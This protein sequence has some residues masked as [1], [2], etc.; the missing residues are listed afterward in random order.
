M[1]DVSSHAELKAALLA[2]EKVRFEDGQFGYKASAARN[3]MLAPHGHS[4]PRAARQP[5]HNIRSAA[6][7]LELLE[8]VRARARRCWRALMRA[9]CT[10]SKGVRAGGEGCEA[11]HSA[12]RRDG[13][14]PYG[15]R[16]CGGGSGART[17][18][19]ERAGPPAV[20][21]AS[22]QRLWRECKLIKLTSEVDARK[23]MLFHRPVRCAACLL[24]IA[25]LLCA[26]CCACVLTRGADIRCS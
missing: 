17:S 11:G 8:D 4:T 25:G 3:G 9:C 13:R 5:K 26:A 12:G 7:L 16:G 2:N 23:V 24:C 6:Q 10:A 15:G 22:M 18:Q 20:R 14:V 19:Q 21:L 1:Q